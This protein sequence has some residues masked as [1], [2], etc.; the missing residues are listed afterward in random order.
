[1]NRVEAI[2]RFQSVLNETLALFPDAVEPVAFAI[3]RQQPEVCRVLTSLAVADRASAPFP[4]IDEIVA[5]QCTVFD[6]WPRGTKP[7]TVKGKREKGARSERYKATIEIWT[8]V[9]KTE[10]MSLTKGN[11]AFVANVHLFDVHRLTEKCAKL[12]TKDESDAM[13][14]F[15]FDMLSPVSANKSLRCGPLTTLGNGTVLHMGTFAMA[16]GHAL[17]CRNGLVVTVTAPTGQFAF[18]DWSNTVSSGEALKGNAVLTSRWTNIEQKAWW[19][20]QQAA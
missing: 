7:K 11:A 8:K 12:V 4:A 10:K 15:A 17:D 20:T 18:T 19:S 5:A 3:R 16:N 9:P 13:A 14:Q 1:M 2:L 6:N